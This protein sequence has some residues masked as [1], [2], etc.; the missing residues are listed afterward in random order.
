MDQ[1]LDER[2]Q[3]KRGEDG[4]QNFPTADVRKV[5]FNSKVSKKKVNNFLRSS[6]PID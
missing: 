2:V 1:S 6:R 5:T 4:A 3:P